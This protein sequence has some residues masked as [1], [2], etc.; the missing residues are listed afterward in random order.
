M[1]AQRNAR[2]VKRQTQ[3]SQK[4]PGHRPHCE[5]NSRDEHNDVWYVP[6]MALRKCVRCG[7]DK[8]DTDFHRDRSRPDGLR[9]VCKLCR[10]PALDASRARQSRTR[11]GTDPKRFW[12]RVSI[13]DSGCWEWTGASTKDGYG[14]CGFA[15]G[16]RMAHRW[17]W[18]MLIGPIPEGQLVL[19]TCDN[20]PCV[21]SDHLFLGTDADNN[22]DM[23]AKRRDRHLSH[24]EHWNAKLTAELV[25]RIREEFDLAKFGEKVEIA[26]KVGISPQQLSAIGHWRSWK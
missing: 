13:M 9:E 12:E 20:P 4:A 6:D 7:A 18:E 19:H 24:Q 21:R 5:F 14:R 10:K 15:K 23:I 26:R 2:L 1:T 17:S 3:R 22:A 16:R 8:H 25:E 11:I